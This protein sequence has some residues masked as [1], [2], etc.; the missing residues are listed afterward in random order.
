MIQETAYSDRQESKNE[1]NNTTTG[2]QKE[3]GARALRDVAVTN[4]LDILLN[5]H[6]AKNT[7]AA[8]GAAFH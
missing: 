5:L 6:G 1:L 8:P 3:Y 7:V 4:N 2:L